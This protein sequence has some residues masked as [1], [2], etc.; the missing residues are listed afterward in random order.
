MRMKQAVEDTRDK[1]KRYREK[2]GIDVQSEKDNAQEIEEALSL[3]QK[4]MQRG[5]YATAV[6]ALEKV[7]KYCS[8]NSQVGGQVFLELGMAYE[9]VGR[10][11]EA[12]QVYSSL[13]N[14]RM[15]DIKF[16]SM[17]LLTGIEAITFMR[18][19][20]KIASF[21]RKKSS[22]TFI[23]T[24]GLGNIAN[25]FD[26][27]YNTAYIDLDRGGNFFRKLTES[28]VRSVREARQILLAATDS[29]EVDR[30]KVV[31]A[32]RSIDRSFVKELE[33]EKKKNAPK[34]EPV[35]VINGV[36]IRQK[37]E[38]MGDAVKGMD[39][40]NLG[41]AAQMKENLNGEWKLQLIADSKGDGVTY[42]NK[43]VSWQNFDVEDMSFSC[44]GSTAFLTL[45]QKGVFAFDEDNRI[46]S[47]TNTTNTGSGAFIKGLFGSGGLSGAA[48]STN[49]DQQIIS[50]DSELLITR[51]TVPKKNTL[52][53]VKGYYSVWRRAQ[54]GVYSSRARQ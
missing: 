53:T 29:G 52:D 13:T 47:R 26:D 48:A 19:D 34:K 30:I 49:V 17:R 43:T 16:N 23:D 15:E 2:V 50:V 46:L 40:F 20:A 32:L 44:S 35:A 39:S 41:E 54:N 37:D 22:Q 7:T 45:T 12:I 51:L 5:V 14:S 28:V 6:S 11:D 24:T 21:S 38:D 1:L 3:G 8:T 27:K 31:Q 9:A 42:F 4:A 10:T 36:P 25:N 18:D 33:E